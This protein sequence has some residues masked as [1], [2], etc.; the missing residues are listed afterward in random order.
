ME[1]WVSILKWEK[2]YFDHFLTYEV[3]E[4]QRRYVDSNFLKSWSPGATIVKTIFTCVYVNFFYSTRTSRPI[5]IKLGTNH[6]WVKGIQICINEFKGQ[7]L[8]KGE[9]IT[10]MQKISEVIENFSPK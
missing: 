2:T 3:L 7:L 9:I 8:F 1:A 10:K 4:A 6:P 5:S